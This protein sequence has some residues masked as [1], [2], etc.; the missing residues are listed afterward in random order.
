[1]PDHI[2]LVG[3]AKM[4]IHELELGTHH[5]EQQRDFYTHVLELPLQTRRSGQFQL[6]VGSSTLTFTTNMQPTPLSYHFAFNIPSQHFAAAKHWLAARIPLLSDPNGADEFYFA[7]WSAHAS[8]FADPAGNICELIARH[9]LPTQ[10]PHPFTSASLLSISEIGLVVDDVAAFVRMVQRALGSPVYRGVINDLF[11][12]LGDENGL[13]IV[14]KR[15]RVWFP[16][17][18]VAAT[19]APLKL[20]IS[21]TLAVRHRIDGPPYRLRPE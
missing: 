16:E 7:E 14:V 4:Y 6:T 17:S 20:I 19:E 5:L 8:Y 3:D 11:T 1:M 13:L 18:K 12:P 21:D 15:G 10:S 2:L 9:T